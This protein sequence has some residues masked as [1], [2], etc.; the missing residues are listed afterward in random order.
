MA[1]LPKPA[2]CRV[3]QDGAGPSADQGIDIVATEDPLGVKQPAVKVQCKSGTS[4]SGSPEVQ[5]LNGT[6][7]P[8][9]QGLFISVSGFTGAARQ[10]AAGMPR[11][12]LMTGEDL[13]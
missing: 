13:V 1:R 9:D 11:M 3:A 2:D 5:A 12:R 10:V 6:L 4:Q 8:T 7:A